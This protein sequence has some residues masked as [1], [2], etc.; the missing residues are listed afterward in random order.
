MSQTTPPPAAVRKLPIGATVSEAYG[1]VFGQLGLVFRAAV[2]PFTLSLALIVLSF[3]VPATSILSGLFLILGLVPYAIFGVAWHRLTLLGPA[4]ATPPLIPGWA[5]RHWRFLGYLAAVALVS[6]GVAI[7][8]MTL[9]FGVTGAAAN[10]ILNAVVV[11]GIFVFAI[12]IMM[13][14]SFVFPAIAV[15]ESYGLRHAWAHTKGQGFRLLGAVLLTMVPIVLLLWVVSTIFG[16]FVFT[17]AALPEGQGSAPPEAQLQ[18]FIEQNLTAIF[19]LLLLLSA[20]NYILIALIVSVISIA[21]RTCTG[22]VPD[23]G[24]ATE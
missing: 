18:A 1:W 10:P 15:D 13:R 4:V 16:A 14:F 3:S 8:V 17:E 21:F 6:N 2:F 19:V 22:W 9:A 24:K 7:T 23:T 5:R 12:Y 20:I 11:P